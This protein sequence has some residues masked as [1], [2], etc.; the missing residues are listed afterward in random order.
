LV[1]K[2]L[3][4]FSEILS[5]ISGKANPSLSKRNGCRKFLLRIKIEK[6]MLLNNSAEL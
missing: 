4:N 1:L 6:K 3:H 5:A 2:D